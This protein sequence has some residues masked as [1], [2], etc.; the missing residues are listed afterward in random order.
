MDAPTPHE[1]SVL[2]VDDD[3]HVRGM[4]L[5]I[6]SVRGYHAWAAAS[7]PEALRLLPAASLPDVIL[8]DLLM[9][10]MDGWQFARCLR[11]DP[12]LASIPLIVITGAYHQLHEAVS[13][14]AAAYITKPFSADGLLD[15]VAHYCRRS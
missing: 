3:E 6:L 7:G 2:V 9:P 14:N 5:E 10:E 12:S 1:R 13:L 4:L 11:E 15:S 8:L